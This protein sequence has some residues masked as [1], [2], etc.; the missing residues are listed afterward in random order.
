[1]L[2]KTYK[3]EIYQ[4]SYSGDALLNGMINNHWNF[5]CLNILY[6]EDTEPVEPVIGEI[7]FG[8]SCIIIQV[9]NDILEV[10]LSNIRLSVKNIVLPINKLYSDYNLILYINPKELLPILIK[11]SNVYCDPCI[12]D[13]IHR[14]YYGTDTILSG[15]AV[16]EVWDDTSAH[17]D[18]PKIQLSRCIIGKNNSNKLT[19]LQFIEA[20]NY[21]S[22]IQ[23]LKTASNNIDF[24]DMQINFKLQ[25]KKKFKVFILN[26]I[27]HLQNYYIN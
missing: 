26:N 16:L 8:H 27:K 2:R 14:I 5:E 20:D 1:M 11:T 9:I 25:L 13:A 6:G 10:H 4:F 12:L 17:T 18:Y 19:N 24:I 3:N 22:Y 15:N 7:R 23:I 21:G